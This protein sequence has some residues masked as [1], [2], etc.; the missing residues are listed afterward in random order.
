MDKIHLV[1]HYLIPMF[2]P[3]VVVILERDGFTNFMT[4]SPSKWDDNKNYRKQL[5]NLLNRVQ[6]E[7]IRFHRVDVKGVYVKHSETPLINRHH[8]SYF[9]TYSHLVGDHKPLHVDSPVFF[10]LNEEENDYVVSQP[11]LI[12]TVSKHAFI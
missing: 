12:H 10:E 11:N 5:N 4:Y 9:S 8:L 7:L 6:D 3:L 1:P 2:I